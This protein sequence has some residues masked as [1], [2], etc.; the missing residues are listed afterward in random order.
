MAQIVLNLLPF[1][2]QDVVQDVRNRSNLVE[3]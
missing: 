2:E 3:P 1:I